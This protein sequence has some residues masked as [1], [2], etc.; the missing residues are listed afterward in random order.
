MQPANWCREPSNKVCVYCNERFD[1]TN[2][3]A[4]KEHLIGRNFVP[5]GSL[6]SGRSF[7]FIFN[8]CLACN[9]DK[10]PLEGHISAIT[11]F[12][13]PAVA[14]NATFG[15]RAFAKSQGEIH[16]WTRR[17]IAESFHES[18][19]HLRE[20]G[21]GVE[22]GFVG[23]PQ[24]DRYKV[25]HLALRH[26]QGLYALVTNPDRTMEPLTLLFPGWVYVLG[27]YLQ[28]DWGNSQARAASDRV[29]D[30]TVRAR[31]I[32]AGGYFQAML[33]RDHAEVGTWFWALEWNRYMRVIGGISYDGQPPSFMRDLPD[34]HWIESRTTT[35]GAVSRSRIEQPLD[36][37]H[38][39]PFDE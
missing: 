3:I 20:F 28:G 17:P 14:E 5:R 24:V 10:S 11:Q 32:T 1:D 39:D 6:D 30:W 9:N 15:D 22:I 35:T 37:A 21:L 7:N 16:P 19:I 18:T 31:I 29:R 33:R 4:T 2:V 27:Y 36:E 8:A 23:P 13:S 26:V 25:H 34:L 38:D 12:M